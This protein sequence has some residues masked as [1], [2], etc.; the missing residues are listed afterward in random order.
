MTDAQPDTGDG[1]GPELTEEMDAAQRELTCL[2]YARRMPGA[3][4]VPL[5]AGDVAF[6]RA[7]QWHLGSYVP[8]T[9][10][11]TLHDGYYGPEDLAWQA[12]V[13]RQQAEARVKPE[14]P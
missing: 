1:T 9:R 5:F 13:K 10:R 4:N 7:C 12:E 6:Y 3:V 14:I 8:Y 2:E 11:A